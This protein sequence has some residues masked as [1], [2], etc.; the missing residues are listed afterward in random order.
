MPIIIDKKLDDIMKIYTL[1][2]DES[3]TQMWVHAKGLSKKERVQPESDTYEAYTT[4][5]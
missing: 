1:L 5:K 4:E 2:S 3:Q